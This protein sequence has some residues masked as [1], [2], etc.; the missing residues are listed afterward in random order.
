[1]SKAVP[2]W[3]LG[4][5]IVIAG[6][7]NMG[8]KDSGPSQTPGS[9]NSV[10]GH[11]WELRLL[12]INGQAVP[13]DQPREFT[14]LCN[15]G[16]EAMGKSGLNTYRG[17]LQITANGGLLW[18]SASFA[19]TKMAGPPQLMEQENQYLRALSGTSQAFV[20]GGGGRLILRDASGN[21]YLEYIKA[22]L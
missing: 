17:T 3:F 20:K 19:S 12:R 8:G 4:L 16:G 5:A 18:D 6:C 21:I 15:A 7:M 9:M 1:M 11:K 22:G 2:V 13:V 14:F 10:C